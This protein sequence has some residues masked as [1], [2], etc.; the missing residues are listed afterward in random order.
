MSYFHTPTSRPASRAHSRAGSTDELGHYAPQTHGLPSSVAANGMPDVRAVEARMA[1]Q[2]KAP[3]N[4]E[5]A[6]NQSGGSGASSPRFKDEKPQKKKKRWGRRAHDGRTTPSAV[7][8]SAA[9]TATK[10]ADGLQDALAQATLKDSK[11]FQRD[12][13]GSRHSARKLARKLFEGLSNERDY[14]IVDD[15]HPYF[16]TEEDAKASFAVFDKDGNGDISR[17]EMRE[18]V[19]RIYRER[20]A[21]STSLKDMSSAVRKL[22]GI[23]LVLGLIIVIFIWLLIFDGNATLANLVPFATFILGFSFVFG[24]SARTIF[25]SM[26][27]IFS[28]HPYDVGDLVFIDDQPL[29]VREF[30]LV[31]TVFNRVDNFIIIAPNSLLATSKLIHNVRRSG[32]MWE[33]TNIQV[34]FETPLEI[35]HELRASMRAWVAEHNREWGGGME[36]HYNTLNNQNY[37]DMI[38]AFEHKANFQDWGGRWVR[39]TKL[40]KRLKEEMDRLAITYTL[41]VQPVSFHPTKPNRPPPLEG[42]RGVYRSGRPQTGQG[43]LPP[44]A[45]GN[46][47]RTELGPNPGAEDGINLR[48][49]TPQ[50][51]DVRAGRGSSRYG[52]LDPGA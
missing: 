6:L 16:K 25:E 13:M 20:K 7:A 3:I 49:D 14:L 11:L 30:G 26:V 42:L 17:R 35:I 46:A 37:I 51:F 32:S 2:G 8:G 47:G 12:A 33:T 43:E 24:N 31:S 29:I 4:Q 38:V 21:L 18:A 44:D 10:I 23:M 5:K 22:D 27:F 45:L 48:T 36:I 40:M 19:Q 41:P 34:G 28:V 52:G 9:A 50:R 39:R 1:A 15:F